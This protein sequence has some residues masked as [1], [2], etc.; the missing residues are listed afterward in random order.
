MSGN[1]EQL[2]HMV[3]EA[4]LDNSLWPELILELTEEVQRARDSRFMEHNDAK[5]L[6]NLSQGFRRAFSISKRMVELLERETYRDGPTFSTS[7]QP[8]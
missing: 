5:G 6:E 2:T 8:A 7:L 4:S 3:Y 1:F